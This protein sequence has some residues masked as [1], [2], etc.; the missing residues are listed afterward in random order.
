MFLALLLSAFGAESLQSGKGDD[1]EVNKLTEALDRFNR[2]FAWVKVHIIVCLKMR[3]GRKRKER[4]TLVIEPAVTRVDVNGKEVVVDGQL[5][6]RNGTLRVETND[7]VS[8]SKAG[9]TNKPSTDKVQLPL[10]NSRE[11]PGIWKLADTESKA[12]VKRH[13]FRS[14]F[15]LRLSWPPQK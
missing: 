4:T 6:M 15:M 9:E 2:F 12:A 10:L 5:M 8:P 7:Q 13:H 1:G 11:I 3:V 14:I